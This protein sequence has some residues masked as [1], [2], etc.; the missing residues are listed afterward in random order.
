MPKIQQV[1][2]HYANQIA[3]GKVIDLKL[4]KENRLAQ[5]NNL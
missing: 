3:E 4:Y 5:Q 1:I 2:E